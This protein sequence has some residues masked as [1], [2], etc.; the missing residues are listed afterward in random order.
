MKLTGAKDINPSAPK[1]G[2]PGNRLRKTGGKGRKQPAD[3][4]YVRMLR[5][6]RKTKYVLDS[7]LQTG[8]DISS[9]SQSAA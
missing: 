3:T 6:G 5:K 2:G 4:L 9:K 7:G 1:P 8:Y